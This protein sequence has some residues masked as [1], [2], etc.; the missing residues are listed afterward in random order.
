MRRQWH[1]SPGPAAD[2]RCRRR[3]R[4]FRRSARTGRVL[5]GLRRTLPV[6]TSLNAKDSILDAHPLNVGVPGTYSRRCAYEA[7]AAADLIV[8]VG[9]QAG[10]QVTHFWQLPAAGTPIV[11]IDINPLISAVTTRTPAG[12]RGRQLALAG[13]L[14]LAPK[15]PPARSAWLAQLQAF[16]DASRKQAD[17]YS[18]GNRNPMRPEEIAASSLR[19][20]R[21]MRSWCRT[22]DIR[23]VDRADG[24]FAIPISAISAAPVRWAGLAGRHGGAVRRA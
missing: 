21:R 9:S 2:R 3:R 18:T 15:T 17:A 19:P 4:H 13:L 6:A 5:R 7:V 14:A 20:C 22:P 16:K 1:A 23:D 8:F 12:R 10:G 11:Q 24:G